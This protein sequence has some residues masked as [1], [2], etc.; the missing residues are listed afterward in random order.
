MKRLRRAFERGGRAPR[1]VDAALR[2]ALLAVLDRDLDRAE[3]LLAWALRQDSKAVEPYLALARLY[4]TRGE[5]G[6]AIRVHQNLLLRH[7]LTS[8][9]TIAALADLAADFRKGGFLQ[10]AIA[11]YEE[12]L[13][14]DSRHR[15]ALAALVSLHSGV[16]DYP[17]AIEANRR[18]A[19]IEKRDASSEESVLL[20]D[21]ARTAQAEGRDDD[22]RKAVKRALRRDPGS[23]RGLI[24]LGELEAE[25]GRKKKALKAWTM[26]PA[27]DRR[28]GPRVYSQLEAVYA[29]LGRG[30]EF[31]TYLRGLLEEQPTD[32]RARVALAR[33]MAARG[34]VDEAIV[35]LRRVLEHEAD[36]L[37]AR[38]DLGRLLLAERRDAEASKEYA[39]LLDMLDRRG[40]L[41]APEKIS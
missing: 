18:L 13:T 19:R 33:T 23:V 11:S 4:R 40:L 15:G 21:M 17:R 10:R 16:R 29:S 24:L 14:R 12:V 1:D 39:E 35:E 30:P 6:R 34:D 7:D 28:S 26:V 27:L 9:Q 31:E 36:D 32:G 38:G 3:D 41:R 2:D 8:E 22:A 37:Q 25:R 20:V 5:V